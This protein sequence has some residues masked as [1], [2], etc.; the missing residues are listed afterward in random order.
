MKFEDKK[1]ILTFAYSFICFKKI[2]PGDVY[3]QKKKEE[4]KTEI[5]TPKFITNSTSFQ[6]ALKR[7]IRCSSVCK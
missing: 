2:I 7:I 6:L 1:P 5:V 3:G 4:K